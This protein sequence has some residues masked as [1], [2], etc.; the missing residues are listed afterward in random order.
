MT[1]SNIQKIFK[2]C[3]FSFIL[4][5][6]LLL[7]IE[8]SHFQLNVFFH[9]L[10][11]F[12]AD[13]FNHIRYT[14]GRDPYF[15]SI[16][17]LHE[18]IYLPICYLLL[19]PQTIFIDFA[20]MS[21]QD[22]W[23]SKEALL[24]AGIFLLISVSFFLHSLYLLCKKYECPRYL[25][26]IIFFSSLNL[27]AME[28]GNFILLTAACVN[29]FLCTKDNE[30]KKWIGIFCLAIAA[31]FKVF[32]VL[33]CLYYL[34]RKDYKSFIYLSLITSILVFLPFFFFKHSFIENLTQLLKNISAQT[35]I[36]GMSGAREHFGIIP[37]FLQIIHT[38]D[39]TIN[40]ITYSVAKYANYIIGFLT[41]FLFFKAQTP[42]LKFG[43][44]SMM[45]ILF[46]Q[47]AAVYS[48]VYIFPLLIMLFSPNIKKE[49]HTYYAALTLLFVPTL[50]PLQIGK[51][52]YI[53]NNISLI[54]IWALL[55]IT[56]YKQMRFIKSRMICEK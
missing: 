35:P 28:R 4:I 21:L 10:D 20:S 26:V 17:G 8:P 15:N 48:G 42:I 31:A 36:Y 2:V 11:D 29:Y 41:I 54:I 47:Q 13:Y 34:R 5:W 45:C 52:T 27:F 1:S 37:L 55:I 7:I 40:F 23:S 38:S 18:H 51:A 6:G 49:P 30:E 46:P 3:T 44:L 14:A 50:L 39:P 9:K 53:I 24:S 19:Y 33:F 22:C 25:L 12:F 43:L 32:P 16:N 56:S